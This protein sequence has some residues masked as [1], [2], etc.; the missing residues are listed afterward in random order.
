MKEVGN[1]NQGG[2]R[3]RDASFGGQC[4]VAAFRSGDPQFEETDT[5]Y[6]SDL[7]GHTLVVV[8]ANTGDPTIRC[9]DG[10]TL[11]Q[12]QAALIGC[13]TLIGVPPP[14]TARLVQVRDRLRAPGLPE[15]APLP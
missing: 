7:T 4:V 13:A 1:R 3:G 5:R 2:N 6:G 11:E 12:A 14:E 15:G 9:R 8:M 10:V